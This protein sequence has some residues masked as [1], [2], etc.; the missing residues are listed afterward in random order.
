MLRYSD[1]IVLAL[2]F[3]ALVYGGEAPDHS[4]IYRIQIDNDL[5]ARGGTSDQD[6]TGGIS[7]SFI[8][9]SN[10]KNLFS[11]KKLRH[12]VDELVLSKS[13]GSA[14]T[15]STAQM[16]AIFFTPKNI[17]STSIDRNDRPYASLI[18]TSNGEML[19][20]QDQATFSSLTIGVLGSS[21]AGDLQKTIH[22][23]TGSTSPLGYRN[24]ISAGSEPTAKY[25]LASQRLLS[26]G[27]TGDSKVSYQANIGFLTE[28]SASM[29]FRL[30]N[31]STPWWS[32]NPELNDYIGNASPIFPINSKSNEFYFFGGSRLKA[33]LYNAMLQGQFRDSNY[34]MSS[35]QIEPLI[36]HAWLGLTRNISKTSI[37]YTLNYQTKEVKLGKA[38]R[39]QLWGGVQASF[40]F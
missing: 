32:F 39:H 8:E 9:N 12:S 13:L 28:A 22:Q 18:F 20:E 30:G 33:R 35:R 36:L 4:N 24:Q 29:S 14:L 6:Y 10:S 1:F 7:L 19:V 34:K 2:L 21:I 31:L 37:S 25:T 5:F 3:P 15:T 40:D 38:A 23:I 16:G 27:S 26:S 17:E 11:L